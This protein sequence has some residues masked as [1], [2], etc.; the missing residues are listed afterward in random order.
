MIDPGYLEK[1]KIESK[2]S[3]YSYK[4]EKHNKPDHVNQNEIYLI[5]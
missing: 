3:F 5:L 4:M 1:R 2:I